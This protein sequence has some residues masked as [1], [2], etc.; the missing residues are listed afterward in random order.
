[1]R[2]A[3]YDLT[4]RA[5]KSVSLLYGL[6]SPEVAGYARQAHE[7]AII[8]ALG[9]LERHAAIVSR[10]HARQRQ[11]LTGGFVAAAYL[12]RTSRAGDPLL[13][14]HVLV[15]AMGQ[16]A[17]G[18][19]T[20][21]DARAL[22][23]HAKTAGFLYQAVLRAELTRR[24]G[25]EWGPVRQGAADLVGVPRRVVEAFSQRREQIRRWLVELGCSSARAAQRAALATRPGKELGVGESTLRQRWRQRA[26][27]LGFTT[28]DLAQ[29]VHRVELE[30]L[31]DSDAAR[32]AEGLVCP[33]G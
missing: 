13:H 30:L 12:H 26:D 4:F 23:A 22:Y 7:Q 27:A 28:R 25:V 24:L 2:V 29:C 11:E 10:G 8:Q 6:G 20:A 18:R 15:A 5:P 16:G 14:T 21:L 17:D 1:V 31:T 33:E 19:W 32:I 9:Y 3:G